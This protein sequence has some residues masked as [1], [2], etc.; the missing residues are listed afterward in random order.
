MGTRAESPLVEASREAGVHDER[1]LHAIAVVDRACFVPKEF[2]AFAERDRPIP[3]LHEQVTTQP[4]LVA[5]MV[6]ALRLRGRERVLEIG[7]GLGYQCAILARLAGQVVTIERFANLA[8]QARRNLRRAGIDNVIVVHGDGTQGYP[9]LAPY[10]AIIVAA[11]SPHIANPLIEQ[12]VEGGI[13]VQPMG[14]GGNE[15][16]TAF[17][18]REGELF[19]IEVVTGAYFVPLVSE[20]E[21]GSKEDRPS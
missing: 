14:P 12:L 19:E 11:A 6:E 17:E 21:V 8:N 4:S 16:V 20:I 15:V 10:D 1:V 9:R 18:K 7:T 13:L 3:I 2:R 5:K